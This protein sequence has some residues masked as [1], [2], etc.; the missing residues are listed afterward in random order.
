M[1]KACN[2]K[3]QPNRKKR[4]SI[5]EKAKSPSINLKFSTNYLRILLLHHMFLTNSLTSFSTKILRTTL[6]KTNSPLKIQ[7]NSNKCNYSV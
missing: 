3:E 5:R 2:I 7:N 6:L 1:T 4:H